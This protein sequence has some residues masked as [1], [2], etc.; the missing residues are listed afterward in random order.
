[1]QHE[2]NVMYMKSNGTDEP[3]FKVYDHNVI[4]EKED[5]LKLCFI[6][7]ADCD[8]IFAKWN[9]FHKYTSSWRLRLSSVD[10]TYK[11]RYAVELLNYCFFLE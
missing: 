5:R 2:G 1:M 10:A 7:L 3:S 8:C 6:V 11:S 9:D 4:T